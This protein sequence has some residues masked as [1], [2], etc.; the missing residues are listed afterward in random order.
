[1]FWS[2][3]FVKFAT[4]LLETADIFASYN[5]LERLSVWQNIFS[6]RFTPKKEIKC[7]NLIFTSNYP[8]FDIRINLSWQR[9]FPQLHQ[10]IVVVQNSLKTASPYCPPCCAELCQSSRRLVKILLDVI[11]DISEQVFPLWRVLDQCNNFAPYVHCIWK[12]FASL[13]CVFDAKTQRMCMTVRSVCFWL[14]IAKFPCNARFQSKH[15]A[16]AV[17]AL[18]A[19]RVQRK[20]QSNQRIFDYWD[21]CLRTDIWNVV[22]SKKILLSI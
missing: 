21:Y 1:M 17:I 2:V 11:F 12:Y 16:C 6:P 22:E 13:R 8:C 10:S 4:R 3:I 5:V 9:L 7:C 20:L 19:T 14:D 15:I 18:T